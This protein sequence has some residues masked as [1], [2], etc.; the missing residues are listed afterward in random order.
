MLRVGISALLFGL[1]PLLSCVPHF[2]FVCFSSSSLLSFVFGGG[3]ASG[4]HRYGPPQAKVTVASLNTRRPYIPPLLHADDD[5]SVHLISGQVPPVGLVVAVRCLSASG[6]P[7]GTRSM[8]LSDCAAQQETAPTPSFF[9]SSIRIRRNGTGRTQS[10]KIS[11]I[12][13]SM[14]SKRQQ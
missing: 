8:F 6:P 7:G 14:H 2:L 3:A 10:R 13:H 12:T 11:F 5:P 9:F 1:C 4:F